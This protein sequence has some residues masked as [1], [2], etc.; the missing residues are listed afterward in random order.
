MSAQSND[1]GEVKKLTQ[2]C[3]HGNGEKKFLQGNM[4]QQNE[5]RTHSGKESENEIIKLD[6]SDFK[7]NSVYNNFN[8]MNGDSIYVNLSPRIF[9]TGEV[10]K[11]G[12]L[13]WEKGLT[14]RQAISLAGG[15]TEKASPRRVLV[16]RVETGKEREFKS[17]MD[18]LVVPG[19]VIK[20]PGR[21]F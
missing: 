14:V 5:N 1:E 8:V 11:P 4:I 15:I 10:E 7:A 3:P 21:Y 18:D 17:R 19:D 16:I 9:V 12:E 6:L 20:V 2:T 13:P